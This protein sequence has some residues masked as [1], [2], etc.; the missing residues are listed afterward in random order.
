MGSFICLPKNVGYTLFQYRIKTT[1]LVVDHL[2]VP[3]PTWVFFYYVF[4]NQWIKYRPAN[5]NKKKYGI[6]WKS[7]EALLPWSDASK[8][9]LSCESLKIQ[10]NSK[11]E[12][13][14]TLWM[15][16]WIRW[17][18]RKGR[19]ESGSKAEEGREIQQMDCLHIFN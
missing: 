15:I 18:D 9:S 3:T 10:K 13:K 5:I 8:T 17:I 7:R 1:T 19:N 12:N 14:W 2:P 4:K 11:K 6:K 16:R